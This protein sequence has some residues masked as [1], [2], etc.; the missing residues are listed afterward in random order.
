VSTLAVVA[1]DGT[2]EIRV[3]RAALRGIGVDP[4]VLVASELAGVLRFAGDRVDFVYPSQRSAAAAAIGPT[5]RRAVHLAVARVLTE[6]RHRAQ[7]AEHL[8]SA[9]VGPT[10]K[11]PR[12]SPASVRRRSNAAT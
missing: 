8:A 6:P 9:A 12:R 2:C 5:E 11:P 1:L 10:T 4:E 7:R 3:V